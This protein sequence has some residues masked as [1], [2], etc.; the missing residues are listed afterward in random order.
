MKSTNQKPLTQSQVA[1]A[2]QALLGALQ[3]KRNDIG[4]D[5]FTKRK[6]KY[7]NKVDNINKKALALKKE[8]DKIENEMLKDGLTLTG[9]GYNH[10]YLERMPKNQ[11][12]LNKYREEMICRENDLKP[13]FR[14]EEKEI[15]EFCLGLQLGT[16]VATD[17]QPLLDRIN[18]LN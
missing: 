18:K 12:E 11:E 4:N 14:Q 5:L 10:G 9:G 17:M 15:E 2:R 13:E 3:K 6:A 8:A 16:A 1:A 7:I